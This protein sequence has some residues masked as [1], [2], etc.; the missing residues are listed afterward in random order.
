M[1]AHQIQMRTFDM[2]FEYVHPRPC[3]TGEHPSTER[4]AAMGTIRAGGT[5]TLCQTRDLLVFGLLGPWGATKSWPS[6]PFIFAEITLTPMQRIQAAGPP[7]LPPIGRGAMDRPPVLW[8][9]PWSFV[10]GP[11]DAQRGRHHSGGEICF[12]GLRLQRVGAYP[13]GYGVW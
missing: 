3:L 4:G 7:H 1:R 5:E 2:Q 12:R 6:L 10:G 11:Q 8:T 13:G 9:E